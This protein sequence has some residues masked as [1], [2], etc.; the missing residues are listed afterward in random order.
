MEQSEQGRYVVPIIDIAPAF[1]GSLPDRTALGK[2]IDEA[3]QSVGFFVITGHG[4]SPELVSRMDRANAALFDLPEEVKQH[5][6]S[7]DPK[8]HRGYFGL[9]SLTGKYSAGDRTVPPDLSERFVMARE[10]IDDSDPYYTSDD[11]RRIF[12]RNIWPAKVQDFQPALVEYY[13]SMGDLA[14]TLMRLFALGLDLPETWFDERIDKHMAIMQAVNYPEP[15]VEPL[16]G[17]LR[18]SPH[19]DYGALTIL[20]TEDKPGG[21]EVQGLDGAWH[22]VPII[23]G[24]FIINIGDMMARWTND[25][26]VSNVHQVVIPP[27]DR[28]IGSR[29]KSLVFFFHPN[30]D[31]LVECIPSCLDGRQ[32]KYPPVSAGQYI[33]MRVAQSRSD[34][35]R[36]EADKST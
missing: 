12:A 33:M 22:V 6:K 10:A 32:A 15:T 36:Q 25:R 13:E 8:I 3:V 11:A 16:P 31:T 28:M 5:Y 30:Y 26:W 9:G 7:A 20:K 18:T 27:H 24:A 4:V 14:K 29:R 34:V 35:L 1:S 21:L 19:T 17:Q 23:P 2:A